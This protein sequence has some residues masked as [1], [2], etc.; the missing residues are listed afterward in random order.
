MLREMAEAER[1]GGV[2][3]E[4][5]VDAALKILTLFNES[6]L[7][8]YEILKAQRDYTWRNCFGNI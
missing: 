6:R 4:Q 5:D 3:E 1:R 7:W 8:L 2:K